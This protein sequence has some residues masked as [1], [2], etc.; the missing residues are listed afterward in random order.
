MSSL[1]FDDYLY[2][3][4]ASICTTQNDTSVAASAVQFVKTWND[5]TS[6]SILKNF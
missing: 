2:Q 3:F 6:F 1:T 5:V 4:L